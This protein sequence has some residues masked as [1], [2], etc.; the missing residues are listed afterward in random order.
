MKVGNQDS[1]TYYYIS[2]AN[3][4]PKNTKTVKKTVE[5]T[6]KK[7]SQNVVKLK[8]GQVKFLFSASEKSYF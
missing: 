3:M 5:K 6:V 2:V 4:N 8:K 7:Q 1:R